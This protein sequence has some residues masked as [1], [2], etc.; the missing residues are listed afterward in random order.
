MRSFSSR[1][2]REVTS[3]EFRDVIESAPRDSAGTRLIDTCRLCRHSVI[4][5]IIDFG[6]LPLANAFPE[7]GISDV[8]YPL[9]LVRCVQ[10]GSV[11]LGDDVDP[12]LM[13]RDY[14]WIMGSAQA[15]RDHAERFHSEVLRRL[16]RPPNFVVDGSSNDGTFL[17]PFSNSGIRVQ[18]IEPARNIAAMANGAGI[19]T[20]DEYF[21]IPTADSVKDGSGMADVVFVRNFHH[22][23]FAV[24]ALAA[25]NH[26]LADDGLAVVEYHRR[27]VVLDQL[28]YDSIYH[29]HPLF[30]SLGDMVRLL[31]NLGLVIED[32]TDSPISGGSHIL[33]I[34]RGSRSTSDRLATALDHEQKVG[35]HLTE[36]WAR[37]ALRVR[38]HSS[39]LREFVESEV[40]RGS[41]VCAVGASSR[42][43]TLLNIARLTGAHIN[44]VADN[45]PL[46]VGKMLAGARV[47]VVSFADMMANYPGTIVLL[48]WNFGAEMRRLLRD[49]YQWSGTLISPLP[50]AIDVGTFG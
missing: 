37:F 29:E 7:A 26:L 41:R 49:T 18:G 10:C 28:Q 47:P 15:T 33:W 40:A 39:H 8:A 5:S 42:G 36:T 45:S 24:G 22:V 44:V 13:F 38:E 1:R 50:Y 14:P 27:D 23:P 16:G 9:H 34:R 32:V 2:L 35:D 31:A 25:M 6:S 21:I 11:Q 19:P 3:V 17:R 4:E 46:K 48:A 30:F 43:T 20:I 12:D